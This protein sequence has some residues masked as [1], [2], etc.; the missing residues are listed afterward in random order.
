MNKKIDCQ[1]RAQSLCCSIGSA[2]SHRH[3]YNPRSHSACSGTTSYAGSENNKV[4]SFIADIA[5]SHTRLIR[6]IGT[7]PA[8]LWQCEHGPS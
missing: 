1:L 7:V 6:Q 5:R 4:S 8:Q 3:K 2:T